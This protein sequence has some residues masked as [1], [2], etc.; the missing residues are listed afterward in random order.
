MKENN[1]SYNI[2]L[3]K[4]IQNEIFKQTGNTDMIPNIFKIRDEFPCAKSGKRDILAMKN[5]QDGFIEVDYP[6]KNKILK[7]K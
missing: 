1:I 5:E 4:N 3:L 6:C 2:D 7:R